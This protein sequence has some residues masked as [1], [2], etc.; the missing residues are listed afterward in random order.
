M[1]LP[2]FMALKAPVACSEFTC[3]QSVCTSA[4]DVS[5]GEKK[6][7]ERAKREENVKRRGA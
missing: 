4:F 5:D 2:F 3:L 6:I 7:I 1:L